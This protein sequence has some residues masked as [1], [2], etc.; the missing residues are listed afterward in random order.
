[1]KE[2]NIINNKIAGEKIKK[3]RKNKKLTAKE[4]G[5][6][7]SVSTQAIRMYECGYRRPIDEVKVSISKALG[8][9][10]QKLFYSE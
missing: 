1:M 10:V 3:L 8:T 9:S 6:L 7:C 2:K 5:E 4:L